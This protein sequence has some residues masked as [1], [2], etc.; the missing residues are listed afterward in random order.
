MHKWLALWA[1]AGDQC[2]ERRAKEKRRDLSALSAEERGLFFKRL[3]EASASVEWK[4][5]AC[6]R[7]MMR[8]LHVAPGLDLD[9]ERYVSVACYS[10]VRSHENSIHRSNRSRFV[11]V[12]VRH[13]LL[14]CGTLCSVPL[15]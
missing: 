11:C 3:R 5:N 4:G 12:P 13:Y 1:F 6:T 7:G 14:S 2:S 8:R 15:Y 10:R 9:C